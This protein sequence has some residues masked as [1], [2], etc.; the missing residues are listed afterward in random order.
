[1]IKDLLAHRIKKVTS[2]SVRTEVSEIRGLCTDL[3]LFEYDKTHWFRFIM[4][5]LYRRS[6]DRAVEV[7]CF[8]AS[9]MNSVILLS[10]FDV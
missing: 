9:H 8:L 7:L 6:P 5:N 4:A 2:A 1:M 10:L 3:D